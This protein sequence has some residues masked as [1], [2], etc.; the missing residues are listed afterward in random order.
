DRATGGTLDESYTFAPKTNLHRPKGRSNSSEDYSVTMPADIPGAN[1]YFAVPSASQANRKPSL[2][3]SQRFRK[4]QN[5]RSCANTSRN[6]RFYAVRDDTEEDFD[7]PKQRTDEGGRFA[8]RVAV[9]MGKTLW[10]SFRTHHNQLPAHPQHCDSDVDPSHGSLDQSSSPAVSP[11]EATV[12][13][14]AGFHR[15]KTHFPSRAPVRHAS[16]TTASLH[17]HARDG[18][19]V[20]VD[21]YRG[22]DA[23]HGNHRNDNQDDSDT[24]LVHKSRSI[25]N[26]PTGAGDCEKGVESPGF[27]LE[28]NSWSVRVGLER[29]FPPDA[30]AAASLSLLK[31]KLKQRKSSPSSSS[32]PTSAPARIPLR[33]TKSAPPRCSPPSHS[34]ESI[35][36]GVGTGK[37]KTWSCLNQDGRVPSSNARVGQKSV[38]RTARFQS[39][40]HDEDGGEEEPDKEEEKEATSAF[41]SSPSPQGTVHLVPCPSC[42]RKFNERALLVHQRVCEKVFR[43]TRP[44]YN[45]RQHRL[46]GF[47]SGTG[48]KAEASSS[49]SSRCGRGVGRR[50]KG[51]KGRGKEEDTPEDG[52][53]MPCEPSTQVPAATPSSSARPTSEYRATRHSTRKDKDDQRSTGS[54]SR[55]AYPEPVHRKALSPMTTSPSEPNSQGKKWLEQSQNFR[56][57]LRANR[58][59]ADAERKGR[60]VSPTLLAV[61]ASSASAA[62]GHSNQHLIPCPHCGRRFNE[63]AADRHIPKCQDIKAKPSMLRKGEGISLGAAS[64]R[65]KG[66]GGRGRIING[67]LAPRGSPRGKGLRAERKVL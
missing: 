67:G 41:S 62:S 42:G 46:R 9:D 48:P 65:S 51:G 58:L 60:P 31:S 32:S 45:S 37:G 12:G 56:T 29:P 61:L 57:M 17:N 14:G 47:E 16:F 66:E 63:Q 10:S 7:L 59:I 19:R 20:V 34:Q 13:I 26:V 49:S 33:P 6:T 1:L 64:R 44:A 15:K 25:K 53:S 50:K 43:S 54:S 2:C 55:P 36:P 4:S 28:G 39:R 23:K 27:E 38:P 11:E 3:H 35:A 21:G 5:S 40:W 24:L 18:P 30:T 52:F 22:K 8:A